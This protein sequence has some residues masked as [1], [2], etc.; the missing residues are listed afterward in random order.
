MTRISIP[1]HLLPLFPGWTEVYR[2]EGG[3]TVGRGPYV[4]LSK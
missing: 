3:S 4:V 2:S 1:L